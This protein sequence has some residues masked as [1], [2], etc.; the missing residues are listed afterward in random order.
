MYAIVAENL[1]LKIDKLTLSISEASKL[2][3][4]DKDV[5]NSAIYSGELP[6]LIPNNRTQKRISVFDLI[7]YINNRSVI[8]D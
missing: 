1:S 3:G 6:Y 2:I 4:C 5:I 8:Y 7:Q